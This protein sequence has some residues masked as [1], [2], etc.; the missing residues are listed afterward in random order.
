MCKPAFADCTCFN[1]IYKAITCYIDQ[2]S[3]CILYGLQSRLRKLIR[4]SGFV[5]IC[6]NISVTEKNILK[7]HLLKA[8]FVNWLVLV[9]DV[10]LMTPASCNVLAFLNFLKSEGQQIP[11]PVQLKGLIQSFLKCCLFQLCLYY[12]KHKRFQ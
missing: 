12:Q 9:N 10:E 11:R 3:F 2:T 8:T 7:L 4:I 6:H 1:G 5:V